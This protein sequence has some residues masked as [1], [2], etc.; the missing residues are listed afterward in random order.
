M[1]TG[2]IALR[3][4]IQMELKSNVLKESLSQAGLVGNV[5]AAWLVPRRSGRTGEVRP[6][7]KVE[8]GLGLSDTRQCPWGVLPGRLGVVNWMSIPRV[9]EPPVYR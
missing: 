1:R 4:A 9:P 3:R 7:T 2:R 5:A 8:A 6:G